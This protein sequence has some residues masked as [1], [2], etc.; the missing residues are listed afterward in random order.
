[1]GLLDIRN[2]LVPLVVVVFL[3]PSKA[4]GQVSSAQQ[5]EPVEV[6]MIIRCY[7]M[8]RGAQ[9]PVGYLQ[10]RDFRVTQGR[11]S[12]PVTRLQPE[13]KPRWRKKLT[14]P[15]RLLVAYSPSIPLDSIAGADLLNSL[16]PAFERGWEVG[17]VGPDG[18]FTGYVTTQTDLQARISHEATAGEGK[19]DS[20]VLAEDLEAF[21]GRRV[22]VYV[23]SPTEFSAK[24][25]LPVGLF[26]AG[27]EV[28]AEEYIVDGGLVGYFNS[29]HKVVDS[30]VPH[31]A[32]GIGEFQPARRGRGHVLAQNYSSGLF[33]SPHAYPI[34]TFAGGVFHE[35]SLAGAIRGA[36][37]DAAGFYDLEVQCPT[38][39][40]P[41][42]QSRLS[43]QIRKAEPFQVT[44]EGFGAAKSMNF[45]V[46]TK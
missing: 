32:S 24:A 28:M 39:G 13:L 7:S 11:T 18:F 10:S 8:R 41:N 25:D 26:E 35:V 22:L 1:M 29:P 43:I 21:A 40:C 3:L 9:S 15:T 5:E 42:A 30:C 38:M 20:N 17:F 16:A 12:F 46:R 44:L 31:D 14:V 45:E 33:P 34:S 36:L 19:Q 6:R 23:K 2:L 4:L 27:G 37:K